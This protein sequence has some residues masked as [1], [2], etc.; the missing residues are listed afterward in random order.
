M[1]SHFRQYNIFRRLSKQQSSVITLFLLLL[2][3][4]LII[5]SSFL[6][7]NQYYLFLDANDDT[8]QSYLPAYQMVVRLLRTGNFSLMN[9]TSGLGTNIVSLQMVIC[10]P[11][12]VVLYLVGF[13]AGESAIPAALVWTQILRVICAGLVC[14]L[15]LGSFPLCD[16]AK[17]IASWVYAFSAFMVGGAG[18]HYMFATAPIFMVFILWLIEKSIER[19]RCLLWLSFCV[20]VVGIWSLYF[21]YMILLAAGFYAVLRFFQR[22][23]KLTF[24]GAVKWFAPLLGSVLLGIMMASIILWPAAF[25]MIEVSSRISTGE[26]NVLNRLFSHLSFGQLKTQF[27]RFFSDNAEGTMNLWRG[28]NTHFNAPHLYS[29]ALL[30]ACLPQYLEGTLRNKKNRHYIVTWI[31]VI[32]ICISFLFSTAGVVFNAFVEYTARYVFVL[33]PLFAYVIANVLTEANNQKVFYKTGALVTLG[34]TCLAAF[35]SNWTES[36]VLAAVLAVNYFAVFISLIWLYMLS[37][38]ALQRVK[39]SRYGLVALIGLSV[40][41]ESVAG[42]NLNRTPVLA[43]SY[44]NGHDT[45]KAEKIQLLDTEGQD[46]FFRIENSVWG[47]ELRSAFNSGE[48]FGYRSA[49]FYNSV[50]NS[51]LREFRMNFGDGVPVTAGYSGYYG[52]NSLGRAMDDTMADILGIRYVFTNYKSKEQGWQ[53]LENYTEDKDGVTEPGYLYQNKDIVTAGVLFYNWYS[54]EKL[55]SMSKVE[56]Q[57]QLPFSVS[58]DQKPQHIIESKI[59]KPQS[60]PAIQKI[61]TD[62][63]STKVAEGL[64]LL[65]S[66]TQEDTSKQDIEQGLHVTFKSEEMSR[67]ERR[68][69]LSLEIETKKEGQVTVAVNNGNGYSTVYWANHEEKLEEGGTATITMSIPTDT[70]QV[71]I[72][73]KGSPEAKVKNIQILATDGRNYTNEGVNLK[74]PAKGGLIVGTVSTQKSAILVIPVFWEQGWTALVDGRPVEILKADGGLC[75]LVISSGTHTVELKYDTPG[76]YVGVA[77]STVG[78]F[79]W[80][81]LLFLKKEFPSAKKYL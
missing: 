36:K 23:D 48:V 17:V 70:Q 11:F 50:I 59:K 58:L 24:I 41:T 42:L 67:P 49:S 54:Q 66:P 26:Q 7:G 5:Y 77:I 16:F 69:W 29:S 62:I 4:C 64:Y 13:F 39:M 56:K 81:T 34:S 47:W 61:D 51:N 74:N 72:S 63:C 3:T 80:V 6:N 32:A 25:Q 37:K 73:L 8:F 79:L 78:F 65:Y 75:G 46:A 31:A 44:Q 1:P 27:L 40:C 35:F 45:V 12:A 55:V 19:K 21:C 9:L 38:T 2:A 57:V 52:N 30:I 22:L 76:F 18:Q 33:L 15:F 14:Y 28:T 10:D 43:K 60:I 68:V 53:L 71:A 20:F